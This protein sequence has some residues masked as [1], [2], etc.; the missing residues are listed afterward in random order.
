M[1]GDKVG[2][3][4]KEDKEPK[5]DKNSKEDKPKQGDK[6]ILSK[7]KVPP[8][9]TPDLSAVVK[10]YTTHQTEV[11]KKELQ[12]SQDT[13]ALDLK[14]Q[15]GGL[16]S[17]VETLSATMARQEPLPPA[18]IP[19][20]S[21]S[22]NIAC[23]LS[24]MEDADV[25]ESGKEDDDEEPETLVDGVES[26]SFKKRVKPSPEVLRLWAKSRKVTDDYNA[27]DWKKTAFNPDIKAY[28]SHPGAKSFKAPSVD[29]ETPPLKY[30]EQK[31][32]EKKAEIIQTMVGA[33]GHLAAEMLVSA[34][35]EVARLTQTAFEFEDQDIVMQDPRKEAAEVL[36]AVRDTVVVR[37]GKTTR[38]VTKI[39][40]SLYNELTKARRSPYL[41][42]ITDWKN[43][44]TIV[45][46]LAPSDEYLFGGKLAEV[47]KNLKDS[48]QLNPLSSGRGKG[49]N[50][51]NNRG[52]NGSSRGAPSSR[53]SNTGYRGSGSYRGPSRGSY[54]GGYRGKN[55]DK[56]DS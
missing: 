40:G 10:K 31:E 21:A 42:G 24:D 15:I 7:A 3:T 38:S 4:S 32:F 53:G 35:E 44:R 34:D 26:K 25:D 27:E 16:A 29:S 51:W 5:E 50:T 1:V 28:T 2:G 6:E 54:R 45:K 41:A 33:A 47:S 55:K 8:K 30:K 20:S 17:V 14:T 22:L 39:L 13:L 37:Y 12:A 18:A 36:T 56:N 46:R 9:P 48:T 11:L 49:F 23:D 43:T 19:Q 52:G